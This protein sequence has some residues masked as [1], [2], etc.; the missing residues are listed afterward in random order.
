MTGSSIDAARSVV[1]D[2]LSCPVRLGTETSEMLSALEED[3]CLDPRLQP[4]FT[5]AYLRRFCGEM[6]PQVAHELLEPLGMAVTLLR[7]EQ[8]L[9]IIGP[10]T[11]EPLHPGAAE[12]VLGRLGIPSIHLHAYKLHRTRFPIIDPAYAHRGAVSLLRCAGKEDALGSIRQVRAEAAAIT[13]GIGELPQSASFE[14]IEERYAHELEFMDAVAD[15]SAE[16]ALSALRRL[17]GVA[18]VQSYLSTPFLG[19]T[20]LRIM[21]R[22]AAQRGGLPPVIIDAISQEHAQRLHR[23]GHTTDPRRMVGFTTGMVSDFCHHVRRHRQRRYS[24]M[25]REVTAEIDLHLS[26]QVSTSELAERHGISASTLSRRFKAETGNTVAAYVAARR[27]ERA[28]RMLTTTRESVRDIALH[29][30]YEDAN[31]FVK[32]FRAAYGM[33]PT[34]YRAT[35]TEPH[36]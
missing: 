25:V 18:Q 36:D 7:W 23:S 16:R 2:V 21:A 17:A 15:G 32:V 27:A 10:Y 13:P 19:A 5:A 33:T 4:A 28:A 1:Q 29:V 20:I 8:H 6:E 30:G 3:A 14:V 9:L 24:P 12:E 34:A 11:H 22:V 35:H 31:Y 26:H